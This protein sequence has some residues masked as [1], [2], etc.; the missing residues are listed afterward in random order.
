MKNLTITV[1]NIILAFSLFAQCPSGSIYLSSQSD[2]DNFATNYPGCTTVPYNTW[3]HIKDSHDNVSDIYDL[4]GLSGITSINGTLNITSC[5]NLTDLSGLS[6]IIQCNGNLSI[7]GN[8]GLTSLTGISNITEIGGIFYISANNGLTSLAGLSNLTTVGGDFRIE[9]NDALTSLAGLSNLTTVESSFIIGHNDALISLNGLQ[10]IT[11]VTSLRI[12][13]NQSLTNIDALSNIESLNGGML[14]IAA[15]Q[16]SNL[17]ALSGM[18]GEVSELNIW[19]TDNLINID[20]LSGISCITSNNQSRIE[21]NSSLQNIDGLSGITNLNGSLAIRNNNS[22]KNVDGL[23]SLSSSGDLLQIHDNPDL[24]NIDGLSNLITTNDLYISDCGNLTSLA[25]LNNLVSVVDDLYLSNLN[26]PNLNG[27]QNL[28]SVGGDLT[29]SSNSNIKNLDELENLVSFGTTNPY[30]GYITVRDNVSL[31]NLYGL[32]NLSGNVH[33]IVISNNS[34]LSNICGIEAIGVFNVHLTVENNPV[35][36][37]CC[38]LKD[39]INNSN[40]LGTVTIQNNAGNCTEANILSCTP[41]TAISFKE[42]NVSLFPH[43]RYKPKMCIDFGGSTIDADPKDYIWTSSNPNIAFVNDEGNVITLGS[44]TATLTVNECNGVSATLTVIVEA[45]VLPIEHPTIDYSMAHPADCSKALMKV[46]VINYFPTLDGINLDLTEVGPG[47]GA[48]P[49]SISSIKNSANTKNIQMKFMSEE[50]TKY[51][52]YK[53][54]DAEPYL[55]YQIVDYINVYEPIPRYFEADWPLIPPGAATGKSNYVD[56]P[57]IAKRFDWKNYVENLDVDEIWVWGYHHDVD[58]GVFGSE[59]E[60]ASPT[61]V[62][63]DNSWNFG[64]DTDTELPIY[65]KTYVAYWF[66]YARPAN[67]HNQGHQLERTFGHINNSLF[68]N[69]FAIYERAGDAHKPPNTTIEYDYNNMT[70]VMSDIQ[71]WKPNGGIEQAINSST[72]A[73]ITYNWPYGQAPSSLTE[74][75]YY[76]YWMQNIPG[77]LNNIPYNS[78]FVSNWWDFVADWDS[79][80]SSDLFQSNPASP[81]DYAV[82]ACD[83]CTDTKN[84]TPV[85]YDGIYQVYQTITSDAKVNAGDEVFFYAEDLIFLDA[86]FEVPLNTDFKADIQV[87]PN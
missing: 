70:S 67:L 64:P 20:G 13:Y 9:S 66:N 46:L 44:G 73:N 54:A 35:L 10:N 23:Q 69:N 15:N 41:A 83:N 4:S 27:L 34:N 1:I 17:D 71:D 36:N 26:I 47:L 12:F 6:N 65:S 2:I 42:N 43:W 53:D 56:M 3:L 60:M 25:P 81:L 57:S 76:I 59:S 29:I 16:L 87:C 55:G 79:H 19:Q 48:G 80:Y 24:E 63:V 77:Y 5:D 58:D 84:I 78:D 37:N 14:L 82:G 18:T 7:G 30:G 74:A 38:V 21:Y 28:S 11:N 8:G 40:Y 32:R 68:W 51:H 22:L 62:N 61:G 50:R 52:G 33:S 86:G 45:P 39:V 31:G 72:W 85:A 75:N 49:V